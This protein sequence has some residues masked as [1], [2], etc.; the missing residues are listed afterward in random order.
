MFPDPPYPG[1]TWRITHH[2]G[3]VTPAHLYHTLWA[4][5]RFSGDA[6]PAARIN[7]YLIANRQWTPNIREDSGQPDAWRDYQQSLS[8][9]GLIYSLTATRAITLTPLGMAFLDGSMGFSETMTLQALR[10][11]YPNGHHVALGAAG[12]TGGGREGGTLATV[13]WLAG[14][15]LRPAALVWSVIRRLGDI[16]SVPELSVADLQCYL[17]RCATNGEAAACAQAIETGR[18]SGPGLPPAGNLR[19]AQDWAKFLGGTLIF[20]RDPG[21]PTRLTLSDFGR[22]HAEEIDGICAALAAPG[23]FWEPGGMAT[24][25]RLRWYSEFG[26]I[27]LSIPALPD[28]TTAAEDTRT[29]F[30]GG[31]EEDDL[32]GGAP[33]GSPGGAVRLRP[34]GA[35]EL[36]TP[37]PGGA[38]IQS[39]YR[40]DLATSAHRLHDEMVL[41]IAQTCSAKGARVFDDPSSVDLLIAHRQV[42]F[43]VEVKS[44][45]QR[46]LAPRLRY[47]LG[48]ALHYDWL[49]ARESDSPRRIVI[50]LAARINADSWPVDFL[51]AHLG[52]DLLGLESGRL[53]VHSRSPE[54]L[55][56]FG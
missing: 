27:D 56:L 4:A 11:Q 44:V 26:G 30:V 10:F 23:S 35:G 24:E 49:R 47:A 17:M 48:Q 9:L 42:E 19:N 46:N 41:L 54:S 6:D 14:V 29:E 1:F 25:D 50:A 20:S 32:R 31:P 16:G 55:E 52:V 13:Q 18:T 15:R 2:M 33:P 43:L 7:D 39:V 45:T 34:F 51:N 53:R 3:R 5:N 22:A 36:P 28:P 37:P 8:E 40:A 38:T 12:G 21:R